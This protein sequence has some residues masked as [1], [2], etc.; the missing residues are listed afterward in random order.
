MDDWASARKLQAE[1]LKHLYRLGYNLIPVNG[2]H[3]PCVEWKVYQSQRV[4]PEEIVTWANTR[5]FR[6]K[7]GDLWRLSDDATLNWALLTG[8]TPYS[9]APPLVVADCDDAEAEALAFQ[10]CPPTPARQRTGG[11]GLH[12]VYRRPQTGYLPIRSKTVLGGTTYNLDLR[13]DGGYILCPGSL[14][15][16]GYRWGQ[17]WTLELL[18]SL[19]VF[20]PGWLPDER[21]QRHRT[22]EVTKYDSHDEAVAK[23]LLPV[24]LRIEAAARYLDKCPGSTQGRA[25]DNYCFALAVCL[26]WGFALPA[27]DATDLLY[28]WGQKDGN[29]DKAGRYYPWTLSEVVHKVKNATHRAYDG[30]IGDRLCLEACEEE[31]LHRIIDDGTEEET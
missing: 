22:R 5:Q 17:P 30:R 23:V 6:T 20:D 25:A 12:L 10:R 31:L 15:G 26:C 19:P 21:S 13:A 2:K 1:I 18:R 4:T 11:G 27:D 16:A 29:V 24:P 7:G 28:D 3:P 14:G 8:A 9:D